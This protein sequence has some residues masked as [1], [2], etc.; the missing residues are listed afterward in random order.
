MI[1]VVIVKP[2]VSIYGGRSFVLSIRWP[3]GC[4]VGHSVGKKSLHTSQ[5]AHQTRPY[6]GFCSMKWPGVFLLFPKWDGSPWQGHPQELSL[7]VFIY[8]PGW[9]ETPWEL[10][11]LPK[12]TTQC[13]TRARTQT[14]WSRD[15]HTSHEVTKPLHLSHFSFTVYNI[16][17]Y[18][19]Y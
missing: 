4:L 17:A 5:V 2:T 1:V 14:A 9:R 18:Y 3:I 19:I 8:T 16:N 10:S 13:P 12:N 15:K 7:S 6:P 11:V